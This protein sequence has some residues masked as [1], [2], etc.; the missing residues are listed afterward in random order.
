MNFATFKS[1]WSILFQAE[2]IEKNI[3]IYKDERERFK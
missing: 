2:L 1:K 3:N